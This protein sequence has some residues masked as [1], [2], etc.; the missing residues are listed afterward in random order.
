MVPT[1]TSESISWSLQVLS[2]LCVSS[3]AK[4]LLT[5]LPCGNTRRPTRCQMPLPRVDS[6]WSPRVHYGTT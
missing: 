4:S 6:S 5:H 3:V 2:L 1:G